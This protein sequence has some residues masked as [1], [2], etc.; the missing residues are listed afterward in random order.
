[1]ARR[2]R[3]AAVVTLAV[4]NVFTLAAGIAV[5][6]ML[7]PRLAALKVP[8]VAAGPLARADPVLGSGGSGGTGTQDGPLPTTSGLLTALAGPLSAPALGP[9]VS[10]L[11]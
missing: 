5:A 4:I 1:M 8:T 2:T 11:V 7:P 3:L 9:H 10:A 6:R